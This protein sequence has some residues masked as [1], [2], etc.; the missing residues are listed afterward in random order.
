MLCRWPS[1]ASAFWALLELREHF[2]LDYAETWRL[3]NILRSV[4]YW[5]RFDRLDFERH[6]TITWD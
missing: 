3:Q 4:L 1:A 2:L 6:V 5:G